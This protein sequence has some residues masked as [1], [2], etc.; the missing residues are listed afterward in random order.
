MTIEG[1]GGG[2]G[3]G[4]A[5]AV[6]V[7]GTFTD[8][9]LLV[10][11]RLETSKVP[12]AGDRSEGVLAATRAACA[13]A[14]IAPPEVGRFR[15]ATTVGTNALLEG[16]GA[17]T[18][19]VT[20]AGFRDVLAIRRQTRPELYDPEAHWPEPRVPRELRFGID[21]R[22][23]PDGIERPVD[24]RE[25]GEVA[26]R[27]RERGVEAVAVCLLHAYAH[28]GNERTAASVLREELDVPVSASHEVLP[29][30]REYERTATTVADALLAPV[31]GEYLERLTGRATDA[32]LPRP[33]VMQ[34]NGGIAD[35]ET[36]RD[37]PVTTALSGPAAGV[38]GAGA[39]AGDCVTL[40]MGG[41]STDVGLVREGTTERTTE[42][43][44]GDHP[45]RVPMV[46][47]T[48]V[49]AGGGSIARGD[50][51]GA[52]R[53]G[54]E[55]AGADPGPAC[56]GR[57]GT[58]PTVT[59]AAAVLGYLGTDLGDLTLD[60][61]RAERALGRLADEAGLADATAAARGVVRIAVATTARAVRS[62]T[63]ER[64]HDPREFVLCAFG[65]AG[66]MIAAALAAD[67]GVG[68]ALVPRGAGVLSAVGLLAADERH[69]AVRTYRTPLAGVDP[70][71]VEAVY[72]D[73][74]GRAMADAD[75]EPTLARRADC[76]YAGQRHEVTVDV[77]TPF[78]PAV[79]RE[80]FHAAHERV[81]GYRMDEPVDLVALGVTATV[82]GSLPELAFD[83]AGDPGR[84]TRTVTFG[85][86]ASD[87][88]DRGGVDG[89][90]TPILARRGLDPGRTVE[91]PA[92]VEGASSTTVVPPEWAATVTPAGHLRLT[93]GAAGE[94][95]PAT[96]TEGR[97]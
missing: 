80:R 22:A 50:A 89:D 2:P 27:I 13:A 96:G 64:G 25:V 5:L 23:T 11:G 21:E 32:G 52:L 76:R 62:V 33:R 79:V 29:T 6:D 70:G 83:P 16:T 14:G 57:G 12:T 7:G 53:V 8:A 45:V 20:T 71:A 38:V 47:V 94:D 43:D 65:G 40:D 60:P 46:D 44:V 86:P 91:G 42:A 87:G 75:G 55:S 4:P 69:D 49:G 81:R 28:P 90:E 66:P 26:D 51:G 72:G 67:L 63:V 56:Y 61:T 34:S 36:V 88:R 73:L 30:F 31:V 74:G 85:G 37:R 68:T 18:A 15:H 41:T 82:A 19:L 92:V 93:D 77:P 39:V 84:G 35:P 3:D 58:D 9:A 78:D 95:G 17:R 10:D 54:P 24:E 59:D 97:A 1:S 48:T